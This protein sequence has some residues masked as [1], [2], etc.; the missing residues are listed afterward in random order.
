VQQAHRLQSIA[1]F[2]VKPKVHVFLLLIILSCKEKQAE[3]NII[4]EHCLKLPFK[5]VNYAF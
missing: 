4:A 2:G 5:I 1:G 3:K